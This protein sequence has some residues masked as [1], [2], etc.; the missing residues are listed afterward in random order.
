MGW[1]DIEYRLEQTSNPEFDRVVDAVKATHVNG[2][3]LLRCLRP[4][5]TAF[6]H[7]FHNDLQ[8]L[9]HLFR[10]FLESESLSRSVPELEISKPI[11][12]FPEFTTYSSYEFEG[13]IV[14]LL[15][16]GGAYI[17]S[18][19]EPKEARMMAVS[20]VDGMLADAR[21]YAQVFRIS[22]AWSGWFYDVAW[23]MSFAVL[24]PIARKW[25]LLCVTDTD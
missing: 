5:T 19:I 7:A 25:W 13:A 11:E 22:G 4:T 12:P 17:D 3:V 14:S 9:H 8:G 10:A 2:G 1:R 20:F 16:S 24:D 15:L 23:D 21:G 18:K 6:D